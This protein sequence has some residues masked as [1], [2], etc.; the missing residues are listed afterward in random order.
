MD[1]LLWSNSLVRLPRQIGDRHP[2]A[3]VNFITK[4]SD[5]RAFRQHTHPREHFLDADPHLL[6]MGN[7]LPLHHKSSQFP[8]Y[9]CHLVLV[10]HKYYSHDSGMLIN[11]RQIGRLQYC[12]S[13]IARVIS[14]NGTTTDD[15]S[16]SRESIG[17]REVGTCHIFKVATQFSEERYSGGM[18]SYISI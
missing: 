1:R 16:L 14:R 18:G 8:A 10:R 4:F 13:I 7:K 12:N 15:V 11:L 6:L 3:Q 17:E 5:M 2:A 9:M